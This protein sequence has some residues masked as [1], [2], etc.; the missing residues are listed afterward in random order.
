MKAR[1]GAADVFSASAR[2]YAAT[3]AP[4]LRPMAAEVVHRAGLR[5]DERVLDVGTGTG[6][7]ARQGLGEG[8]SVIGLDAA[9]GML[10]IARL[11]VPEA[12]FVRASFDAMP[13][14][15]GA[16]D[17]VI[18]VHALLFAEDSETALGEWRR[19]TRSGGR[20]SLS[21]PGP[22]EHTPSSIYAEIYQRYEI[23]TARA[24]D[25]PTADQLADW[26]RRA[27]WTD[28]ATAADP[29]TRIRLSDA[30]AFE[31]WLTVGSRG[32]A[33]RDWSDAR[34]QA[35]AEELMAA[36]PRDG[37]GAFAIPFGSLYLTAF[38]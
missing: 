23:V 4:S 34:R 38:A 7:G 27:G 3:M 18:A 28:V 36:T 5:P 16:F 13:F 14:D 26:A 30:A 22:A 33:T 37:N 25:Y 35:F 8:R 2:A 20:L 9:D 32:A 1:P 10:A 24:A 19:V 12:T 17:V 21:V 6:I 15:D 11:E 29:D 31:R